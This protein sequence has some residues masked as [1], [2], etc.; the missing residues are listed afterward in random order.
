MCW[1]YEWAR[2]VNN[3][4]Y[5]ITHVERARAKIHKRLLRNEKT[6]RKMS[7]SKRYNYPCYLEPVQ[8]LIEK[9]REAE[10]QCKQIIAD[11]IKRQDQLRHMIEVYGI[12]FPSKKSQVTKRLM[13]G[14][15][16]ER[17]ASYVA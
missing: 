7:Q 12:K 15:S 1:K 11:F 5:A 2:A 10:E 3:L 6:L 16:V 9:N 13:E 8:T 17:R 14:T 4:N